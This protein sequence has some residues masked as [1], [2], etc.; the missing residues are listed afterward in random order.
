MKADYE[1]YWKDKGLKYCLGYAEGFETLGPI[2]ACFFLEGAPEL[3]KPNVDD[4]TA[5]LWRWH[6]AE[7]Y[8]HRHV[9]N[10]LFHRLYPRSYWY[11]LYGIAYAGR[12]MLS[13]MIGTTLYVLREDYKSGRIKDPW[14][15]RLRTAGVLLR[16]FAYITPRLIKA[17]APKY[18]PID[19]PPPRRCMEVLAE[20]E[21]KWTRAAGK[22]AGA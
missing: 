11:R 14:R 1:H 22:P 20:T 8:E 12:H 17:M 16:L 9:C 5:D 2:I 4:P 10:Y 15:S 21:A 18:D 7:E 3:R 13:Y 19:I 6:L